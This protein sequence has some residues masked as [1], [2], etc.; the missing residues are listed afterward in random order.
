MADDGALA[1]A[2]EGFVPL[3]SR[4]RSLGFAGT[5]EFVDDSLSTNV[6]PT[7]AALDA[8]GDRPVAVL[9]GGQDRGI[10]YGPL[11]WTVARRAAPT[12]VVT[13]PDNGPRIGA[14][15]RAETAE[16]AAERVEVTDTPDLEA[17][18][19][20]AYEWAS[21]RG[22]GVVVLSPAAPSF[23]RYHDYRDRAASFARA[24]AGYGPLI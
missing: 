19:T 11:G 8:F 23:G 22:G 4:C 21:T 10:D 20:A 5:V 2:A 24:A 16:A 15:V 6:L 14:T 18:V 3:P 1:E 13:M 17:A 12:L 7:Q 9:V